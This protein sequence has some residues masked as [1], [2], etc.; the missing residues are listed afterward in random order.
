MDLEWLQNAR[1]VMDD[2]FK[3]AF[4]LGTWP[5]RAKRMNKVM[6]AMHDITSAL[7]D[8]VKEATASASIDPI[9]EDEQHGFPPRRSE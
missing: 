1:S 7:Y 6:R 2:A 9:K 3:R 4:P 5:M 8:G